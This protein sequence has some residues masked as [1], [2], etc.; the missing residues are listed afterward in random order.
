MSDLIGPHIDDEWHD[1]TFA[2]TGMIGAVL[3]LLTRAAR[4]LGVRG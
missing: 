4:A 2:P 1:S 3:R